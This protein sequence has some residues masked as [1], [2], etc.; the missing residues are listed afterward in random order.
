MRCYR[1]WI[2]FYPPG[3]YWRRF[4]CLPGIKFV[5]T[6]TPEFFSP[7][8]S[9]ATIAVQ[10]F[11]L[12]FA[13]WSLFYACLFQGS[14]RDVGRISLQNLVFP[15]W[16]ALL[17][18]TSP[19]LSNHCGLPEFRKTGVLSELQL[20]FFWWGLG[21]PDMKLIWCKSL[22]PNVDLPLVSVCFWL[23]S[24]CCFLNF[25]Q[26]LWKFGLTIQPLLKAEPPGF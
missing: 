6:P 3:E 16:G 21:L 12:S 1:N 22:F 13:S 10:L 2:L 26:M 24:V 5:W 7:C 19:S 23:C 15:F 25:V 4:V 11:G 17:S 20:F 18:W 8:W 9:A 14:F